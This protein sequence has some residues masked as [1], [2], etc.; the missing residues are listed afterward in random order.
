MKLGAALTFLGLGVGVFAFVGSEGCGGSSAD[1]GKKATSG[2]TTTGKVPPGE[3]GP[4]A[5]DGPERT[6]AINQIWLGETDRAGITKKDAWKTYGY[7][8]DGQVTNVV[9]GNSPDLAHVCK[10]VTSAKPSVHQDGDE[11]IDN[12]F[13]KEILGLLAATPLASPSR[14]VTDALQAGTFT[15]MLKLKGLT[16]DPAQTNTALGGT[17]LIGGRFDTDPAVR[18]G[19][20]TTDTWPFLKDPQVPITGAYIRN[21]VFVNGKG[22]SQVKLSLSVGGQSLDL[23]V[24]GALISFKHN[25]AGHSLDEGTIAGVVRTEEFVT[26]IANIAGS[27]GLCSGAIVEGIKSSV[28]F[29]SDMM[30]DGTQ[31]PAATCDGISIGLGFT[32]KQIGAPTT[33]AP[34][35]PPAA[36][37]CAPDGGN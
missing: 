9:D 8:L 24:N 26:S 18:P 28:R 12:A 33:E 16:D 35:P 25:P 22:G 30:A 15:I 17:I 14:S 4:P 1:D 5:P 13:G 31:N 37:P 10:R 7:N 23:T 36:D 2:D 11:G 32:A 27:L 21:G 3:E 6:F 19:F 34:P 29:A 20:L